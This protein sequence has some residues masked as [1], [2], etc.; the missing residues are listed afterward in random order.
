[1]PRLYIYKLIFNGVDLQSTLISV[2]LWTLIQNKFRN[3]ILSNYLLSVEHPL[4]SCSL[5]HEL[6]EIEFDK[7]YLPMMTFRI[8]EAGILDWLKRYWRIIHFIYISLP[9]NFM[10]TCLDRPKLFTNIWKS[11]KEFWSHVKFVSTI[12]HSPISIN[13]Q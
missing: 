12:A 2:R 1:M 11:T 5:Y 13:Y 6:N 4:T 3:N 7:D 8:P 10:G 9:W